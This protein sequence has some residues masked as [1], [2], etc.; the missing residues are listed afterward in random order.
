MKM[1]HR[2]AR[3]LIAVLL[4]VAAIAVAAC[5]GS[6]APS[7]IQKV[8][9]GEAAGMLDSRVV[10]DVRTPAEY[11]AGHIA[12]AQNISV[13]AADFASRIASLDKTAAYLV[14]CHSG[15]RSAIAADQ[16]AAAGFSDIV[17][18]GGMADLVAAGARVQ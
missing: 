6:T 10:I 7:A 9:A 4:A 8:S 2:S 12:G 14:Y 13:E 11:A 16:M 18:A 1:D 17:D 5:G 15:R 3:I